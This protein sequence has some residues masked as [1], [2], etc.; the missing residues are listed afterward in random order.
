MFHRKLI[1]DDLHPP[2]LPEV[3]GSPIGVITPDYIGELIADTTDSVLYRSNGLTNV[4]WE[5]I[6]GAGDIS[7]LSALTDV[8]TVGRADGYKLV[9][10]ETSS[11]HIFV[12]SVYQ[13]VITVAQSGGDFTNPKDAIES[14]TDNSST[15]RYTI[16]VA[17]GVY[18]VDNSVAPIQLK[19]FCSIVAIGL[20]T[21]IISPQDTN[22]DLFLGENFARVIGIVFSSG[23]G[24]G[25]A[26]R[27]ETTGNM[28]AQDCVLRD[29]SNGFISTNAAGV[30]EI[31]TLA[32][33]SPAGLTT[34]YAIRIEAG[35]SSLNNLTFRTGS[36]VTKAISIT[37][38]G[39][40]VSIHGLIAVSPTIDT[41]IECLDGSRT[42][43]VGN[44]IG[45]CTNGLV[46]SGNDTNVEM[47]ALKIQECINDGFR[48]DNSGTG[49]RLALFATT[50]IKCL[51]FNF[52]VLNADCTVLGNG[53][54]ELNNAFVVVG[55]GFHAYLLDITEGDEGLNILGELHVGTAR[56]PTESA[57]GG[58]DSY[59]NGMLVYTKTDANVFADVSVEAQ[60]KSGSVFGFTSN[61]V[62]SAIYIASSLSDGVD[63][64]NHYG[65]KTLLVTAAVKGPT[66]I[67]FE[68]WNGSIWTEINAMEV[69]SSGNY[70]P[71]ANEYFDHVG[72]HHIRYSPEL[73]QDSWTK[74]DPIIPSLGTNYYWIRMRIA[75]PITTAPVFQQFKLHTS[76]FEINKDGWI[77]YFG[78]ARPIGQLAL[79]ITSGKPLEG[80]MQSQS[81]YI[82]EN[83]GSGLTLNKF[84]ATGD[85]L[86]IGGFLPFDADTS[87]P[88]KLQWAG[89]A[90]AG[91]TIEWTVRWG[92]TSQG[93][94]YYTSDPGVLPNL[95][96]ILVN[97]VIL[98]DQMEIFEALLPIPDMLSR[99]E[100]GFGDEIWISI[101]PSTITGTFS[102]TS[103][104]IQYTKWCEGG[105]I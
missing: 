64:L 75:N 62:N 83:L 23:V 71:H 90:S 86:G 33:N 17:P 74:N 9:W 84:T 12:P 27:H 91:Q 51:G 13:N 99:R 61:T 26:V 73:V 6:G 5:I 95:N 1:G 3:V 89:M 68:Y 67:V 21:V 52:N 63:V 25:Y 11:K 15:N 81:I 19:A 35:L 28:L 66:D 105:H 43:G 29:Y 104:Q 94:S 20:R 80:N 34:G 87:A 40:Q 44:V 101:Q 30:L 79:N 70:H 36:K 37:G 47:D 100:G 22:K 32:V 85:I 96:S 7:T 41:S 98:A 92:H 14:I 18:T 77:E 50:V 4:D 58:G 46:L 48:I 45:F 24:T 60:S 59:T 65:I 49:I 76:R 72:E 2:R 97:K 93:D 54:T 102:L 10:D 103:S 78:K 55:A 56:R 38:V 69:G 16:Q 82:N 53:F 88:L 57:F 8:N 39:T 31:E 42:I